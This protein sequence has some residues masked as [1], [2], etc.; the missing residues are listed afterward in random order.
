L[1]ER[2]ND[3]YIILMRNDQAP[4]TPAGPATVDAETLR[5]WL[6]AGKPIKILDVRPLRERSEWSIPGS[7]HVDAYDALRAHDP[8]ALD[9]VQLPFDVPIV[10]VC[11]AGRTSLLAAEV[12]QKLGHA[13][14]SLEL[15]MAGWTHAWNTAEVELPSPDV[16]IIQVRR[17]GKG[18]L[19][20][21]VAAAGSAVVI[22]P[23]VR[24]EVYLEISSR[25]GW[26]I[27]G[28]IDTHVHADHLSRSLM[29]ARASGATVHLPEQRRVSFKHVTVREGDSVPLGSSGK[30]LLAL[31][32]PG[33][34]GESTC[35]SLEGAALFTG[36]TL[37]LNSVGRPDLEAGLGEAEP[38]GRQLFRSLRRLL[39]FPAGTLVL[40]SHT[41][42]PV[43]FDRVPILST[44]GEV[45]ARI[46]ALGRA[47]EGFL[48]WV[49]T[50]IPT[51]PPNHARII[52]LNEEG[53]LPEGDLTQLEAGANRCAIA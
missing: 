51:P 14:F 13:V 4:S 35:F 10:T 48:A 46:A 39:S 36:D 42:S 30:R 21:I 1:P 26:T 6:D 29:L 2:R 27:A 32:T 18:C 53:S 16:R 9:A 40:P 23:S 41:G 15:G 47:E 28:V 17:T 52:A 11:A 24:P 34:T 31:H 7:I 37:F 50:N 44:L 38:R 3:R 25:E 12:L 5:G 49:L 33:H 22:D 19:S 45:G 43:A 20:Y 8:H